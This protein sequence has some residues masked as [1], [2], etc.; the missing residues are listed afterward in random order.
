MK[1][2]EEADR[3]DRTLLHHAL[4]LEPGEPLQPA[5]VEYWKRLL[6]DGCASAAAGWQ[7]LGFDIAERQ[8]E[9]DDQGCMR[10]VFRNAQLRD[11]A[12]LGRYFLRSD[13]FTCLQGPDEDNST[14]NKKQIRWYLEQYK[15]L[16]A[17]AR[18][19]E[20]RPLFEQIN[21]IRPLPVR[22]ATAY[23]WF[24]L[25]VDQESFRRLP[26]EDQAM[27]AGDEPPMA[28]PLRDLMDGIVD[29]D[30]MAIVEELTA[31]LIAYTP[32]HFEMISCRITEGIEQG[33][34]ALFYDIQCPQFPDDGTTVVN[35]RVHKA[36][37]RLARH[38]T[39][40]NDAFPG[41][42]I[43]LERQKDGRWLHSLKPIPDAAGLPAR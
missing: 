3:S 40:A 15:L 10:A 43:G 37:T 36:A 23:G 14:F 31:A 33:Q 7:S 21:R 13:A 5:F 6:A 30:M 38:M 18:A 8:V 24:D 20:L 4:V 41:V 34:R 29:T 19:A 16:K 32:P 12:G 22:V 9:E 39:P 28:D 27:L 26:S 2:T 17:A 35:D 25:Q 42:V 1:W 11:C